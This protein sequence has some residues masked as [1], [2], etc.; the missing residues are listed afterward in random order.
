MNLQKIEKK[1]QMACRTSKRKATDIKLIAVTKTI[2]ALEMEELYQ[3]GLRDFGEN[4]TDSFLAKTAFLAAKKD[5][6][7][8]FIGTLQTRKVKDILTKIDYLH[9]LDRLS[10]AKE[11]EK[12]A[13]TKI[14]CFLEI[15]ISGEEK[16]HGFTKEAAIQFVK[17]FSFQ[18]IEIVGLMAMAPF[19]QDQKELHQV[20]RDLKQVQLEIEALKLPHVP[21][22]ELS[23]GMTND[24][25]IAIEEGATSIRIG[26]ALVND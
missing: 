16:K 26:R 13:T 5:I 3:L 17:T 22:H 20:F 8:H 11:I 18:H 19:T 24:Y 4:R 7:W 10:L 2:D 14:K 21:C 12:R 6:T 1:I 9:S 25:P 23:M 15:N